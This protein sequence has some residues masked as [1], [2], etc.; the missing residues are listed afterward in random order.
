MKTIFFHIGGGYLRFGCNGSNS[1]DL[2]LRVH[3]C[4]VDIICVDKMFDITF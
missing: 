3:L 1:L 4:V 2:S